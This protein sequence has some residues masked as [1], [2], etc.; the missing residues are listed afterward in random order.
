MSDQLW[1]VLN[2]SLFTSRIF[3]DPIEDLESHGSSSEC[4]NLVRRDAITN[5]PFEFKLMNENRV[6]EQFQGKLRIFHNFYKESFHYWTSKVFYEPAFDSS[7]S[8][9]ELLTKDLMNFSFGSVL[10]DNLTLISSLTLSYTE[11][12]T[13]TFYSLAKSQVPDTNPLEIRTQFVFKRTSYGEISHTKNPFS[14]CIL[15]VK[16]IFLHF[17]KIR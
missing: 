15:Q 9:N 7:D 6:V 16:R 10:A 12:V 17:L 4:G 3:V 8:C 2:E 5:Q 1:L 11:I 13:F 14:D